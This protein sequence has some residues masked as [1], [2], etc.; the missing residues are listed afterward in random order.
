MIR[1]LERP[2]PGYWL[3]RLVGDGPEVPAALIYEQTLHEPLEPENVM[4][5]SPQLVA[6]LAG[7]VV[8]W[9]EVWERRGRPIS[10]AEYDFQL[11]DL[12]WAQAH[13]PAE[14]KASP[15]RPIDLKVAPPPSFD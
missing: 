8:S 10:R 15:T 2:R 1:E 9:R 7:R 12:R 3:V 4:D 5:R 13:A 11:A 14:P 6:Y